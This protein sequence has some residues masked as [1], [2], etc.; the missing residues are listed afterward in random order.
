MGV[1]TGVLTLA[2]AAASSSRVTETRALWRVT[3]SPGGTR[4]QQGELVKGFLICNLQL[5]GCNHSPS[6][7]MRASGDT[8]LLLLPS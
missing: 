4:Q 6:G 7:L 3:F 1:L 2:W 8:V 5:P